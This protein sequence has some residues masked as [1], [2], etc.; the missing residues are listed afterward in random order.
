MSDLIGDFVF[1]LLGDF[2]FPL[3]DFVFPLEDD[4]PG[5]VVVESSWLILLR[6]GVVLIIVD[7]DGIRML[8]GDLGEVGRC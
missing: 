6:G 5:G 4:A 3:G 8:F 1:A 7:E 2:V